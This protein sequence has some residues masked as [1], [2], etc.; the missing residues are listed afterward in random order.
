VLGFQ[1]TPASGTPTVLLINT[2]TSQTSTVPISVFSA[3]SSL[4]TWT[5]STTTAS[6]TNPIVQATTTAQ[7][8]SA[9]LSLPAESIVVVGP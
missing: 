2:S 8:V 4:R 9:G 3:G 1:S 6:A 7:Q 5:Y